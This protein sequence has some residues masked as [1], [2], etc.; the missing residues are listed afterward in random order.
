MIL[1]QLTID[2]P[3]FPEVENLFVEAFPENERPL[4]IAQ[5]LEVAEQMEGPL[6][7]ELLGIYKDEEPNDFAGF[8]LVINSELS[9]YLCFF[10]IC[11]EKRSGGIG[12]KAI[13]ALVERCGDIPLMFS[14]ESVFEESNNAVQRERRRAFY[15]KNGFYESGWFMKANGTEF[16]IAS[17]Q[18]E[19]NKE[20]FEEFMGA[21]IAG[22]PGA[23]V[24]ELYRRD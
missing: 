11:P 10:A 2:H 24:P 15:L 1:K 6:S 20:A 18:E 19:F 14:Y 21:V 8:F 3:D 9:K 4:T 5:M 13:K 23:P 12:G 16:I 17:A 22:K 7:F